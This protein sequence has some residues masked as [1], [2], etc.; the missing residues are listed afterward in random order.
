MALH[1]MYATLAA[2]TLLASAS[3]AHALAEP[4]QSTGYL[5]TSNGVITAAFDVGQN[6]VDYFNEHP[7]QSASPNVLSRNFSY[8]TYPGVRV[9]TQVA[10]LDTVTPTLVEYLAGTG[11]AHVARSTFGLTIDEYD[12]SPMGLSQGALFTVVKITRT[13]GSGAVDVYSL[14]NYH[15]GSGSPLPGTDSENIAWNAQRDAFYEWGPSGVAFGYGDLVPSSFHGSTPNN[16]YDLLLAGQNLDDDSGTGGATTDAVCGH[17]FS[18]G[19]IALNTPAYVGWFSV[20]AEDA[21]A[22]NAIDAVTTF[23]ASRT[24]DVVLAAEV[25]AWQAWQTA[26]PTG[27]SA[28]ESSL[29]LESQAMLRM[30]QVSATDVSDG[31]ILAAIAPGEWNITWVRD[32]AYSTVALARSGH[33]AEAKRALAFE[34]GAPIAGGSYQ[35]YVGSPYQISVVRYYGEGAEWSDS[36]SDGPNI[37]FDGFGL[38][39][40]ALETYVDQT[41]DQASLT[42]WWPTVK[43]Q[44]ADVLASLQ[45][46]DGLIAPDSSIWEVH[47]DGNQE[48]FAYTTIAAARGLCAASRLATMMGDAAS[49]TKYLTAGQHARD[50]I[51]TSLRAPGGTIAQSTESLANGSGW[52]DA[53]V[54]DAINF[55]LIDPSKPT[56]QAT[57]ASIQAGL[58][59][60]SGRGFMRDQ[61][62]ST[63][64]SSEWIFVDMRV[65]RAIETTGQPSASA[66]LLAWNVAQGV[67]N[68]GIL[69]ELHDPVTGD[70]EGAAPMVGFGAGAYILSL[71]DRGMLVLP[72]CDA[73]AAEPG[74]PSDAGPDA[75]D[76]GTVLPD[77]SMADGGS[78][79]PPTSS[80][81]CSCVIGTGGSSPGWLGF[82]ALALLGVMRARRKLQAIL[83]PP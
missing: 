36:N 52:L 26:V 11:I 82:A 59:P 24:P 49:A 3:T 27:A 63:Y 2:F 31:Q 46:T 68:F 32:M 83:S 12:F 54:I 62:G 37:E 55:G 58:V 5:P 67:D 48:H 6:K 79:P 19:D 81:G 76:G 39:L 65:G 29:F 38:F 51:L 75:S 35:S 56:A 73:F 21:N 64:D 8:D 53:A 50:A 13:S 44:V 40:W 33:A 20:L 41:S 9:G 7:Y 71:L 78:T 42:T 74:G 61:G 1:T 69:S 22:Q 43:P 57:V 23:V 25:S 45:E 72:G 34:M 18:L 77:A 60:P 30:A 66:D 80:S 17:Q 14:Y 4:H 15:L 47:W 10:W 16:P 28:D 70:Y